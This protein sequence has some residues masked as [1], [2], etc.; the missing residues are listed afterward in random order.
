MH[1]TAKCANCGR[2]STANFPQCISRYKA[3][4][5]ASKSKKDICHKEKKNNKANDRASIKPKN[6]CPSQA[7]FESDMDKDNGK[8][9]P[10]QKLEKNIDLIIGGDN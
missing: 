8:K 4:L 7:D 10:V 9:K 3:D 2:N 1:I 6:G 5:K